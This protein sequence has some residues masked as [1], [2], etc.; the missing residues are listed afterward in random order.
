MG[1]AKAPPRWSTN[2]VEIYSNVVIV[3]P[4][5]ISNTIFA[6]PVAKAVKAAS[7]ASYISFVCEE[8]M[9]D[10]LI[11]VCPS[12]DDVVDE[13]AFY[14]SDDR[15][16][17]L[18]SLKPD[19]VINLTQET[20]THD[21]MSELTRFFTRQSKLLE[22]E[23]PKNVPATEHIVDEFLSVI[24]QVGIMRPEQP[25]PTMFPEALRETLVHELFAANGL[26]M[27]DPVVGLVP[28]VGKGFGTKAWIA[29]GYKYLI[30]SIKHN[31]GLRCILIGGEADAELCA[32]I[33]AEP[34]AETCINLGGKVTLTEAA[35]ILKALPV[36]IGGDCGLLHIA[37]AASTPVIGL[38]GPTSPV[39]T[40][41]YQQSELVIDVHSRCHCA[42]IRVCQGALP[43][44]GDCI[45]TIALP[46]V[47]ERLYKV[48]NRDPQAELPL[49]ARDSTNWFWSERKPA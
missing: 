47:L 4:V 21:L 16:K 14:G 7:P 45:R 24:G 39:K 1:L 35:A 9:R 18:R 33:A 37:V 20:L 6:T 41:P 17:F 2:G 28:G 49:P 43:G 36:V 19:L 12:V 31:L 48:L 26:T 10:L 22:L 27:G 29:D 25:F 34:E 40:G 11:T 44:P 32:Q 23:R 3:T 46:E 8:K 38:Y 30:D 13:A 42:D 5:G 15:V